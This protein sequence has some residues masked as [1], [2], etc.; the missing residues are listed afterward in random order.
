MSHY[1]VLEQNCCCKFKHKHQNFVFLVVGS[2][3]D[4]DEEYSIISGGS[5][6]STSDER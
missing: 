1:N 4:S 6:K 3:G 5:D 2:S